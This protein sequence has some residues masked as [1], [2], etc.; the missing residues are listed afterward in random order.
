M[1]TKSTDMRERFEQMS[2]GFRSRYVT[3]DELTRIVHAWAETFPK[4]VRLRSIGKTPEGRDLWLLAIGRSPDGDGPAVWVDGN[5][6]AVELAG[7]SVALAIAEDALRNLVL[8]DDPLH[9][10]PPHMRE[11]LRRD[12][13]FYV[14]PRMCPDG[15]EHALG[16][17]GYVRSNPRDERM[18]RGEPFW[19]MVD[20]DGD[21]IALSMRREDPAGDFVA[22]A[23]V[24]NLM[25]PRRV[26]DAGPF[27]TIYP[28]GTIEHWDGFTI[29]APDYLSDNAIDMNRNFPYQ[30]APEPHQKG[31][32]EYAT[33]EP[34]SRAIVEFTSKHPNIFAWL[35]LHCFGGVYIR[36]AGDKP[37]SKMDPRDLSLYRQIETW[38]DKIGGY[39]MVS[40]YEEFLYEAEK[41]LCGDEVAYAYAQRGAVA[42]VCE[43]WDFW[44]QAGLPVI[45]PFVW[46]YQRRSREDAIKMAE[47]D[48]DH[49]KS[50]ILGPWRSFDHPQLG[51]VEIGGHDPRFGI[52]NPPPERLSE[53]CERQSRFFFRIAALS[54]SL[55]LTDARASHIEGDVW[56]VSAIVENLGYLPT[57]ILSSAKPLAWNDPV[58]ARIALGE[59]MHLVGDDHEFLV[60]HLE[61]WGAVDVMSTPGFPRSG[62]AARRRR[63]RWVVRG[64]GTVVIQTGC[65]RVGMVEVKLDV[66]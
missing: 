55:R 64:K 62:G 8:A 40:G 25:L 23:E 48:R 2:E 14:L 6:H 22:S 50:R 33:S 15:A 4:F 24:P 45:R 19:R 54:P 53:V 13:T 11:L 9:D 51:P 5:M 43:I 57:F 3:Y 17:A 38:G 26:E 12:V 47:W 41:P 10:F 60:G 63:V 1:S 30:W 7:S 28:E 49:N 42:L 27:Y 61:G 44:K 21:G 34:E 39:P 46:N 59:N 18:G 52:W 36:P 58:R 35:N 65:P 29:P 32:G 37:D 66:K 56:E 31:A 20:V 16:K